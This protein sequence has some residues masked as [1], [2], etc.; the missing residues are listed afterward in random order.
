MSD[1]VQR[2]WRD[3]SDQVGR[4]GALLRDRAT[5]P[6]E[7]REPTEAATDAMREALDRLVAAGREL[8]DRV[9]EIAHDDEVRDTARGTARSLD[10]ALRATVDLIATEIDQFVR[11]RRRPDDPDQPEC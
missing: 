2:A 8:G 11:S 9:S 10:D 5:A 3:L 1:D 6:A 7:P 4:L